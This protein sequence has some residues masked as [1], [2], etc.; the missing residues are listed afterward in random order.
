MRAKSTIP[1]AERQKNNKNKSKENIKRRKEQTAQK[2]AHYVNVVFAGEKDKLTKLAT[3][4]LGEGKSE[5]YV[6]I[7]VRQEVKKIVDFFLMSDE[8][9]DI[10]VTLL[11]RKMDPIIVGLKK[12]VAVKKKAKIEPETKYERTMIRRR[13][14]Y[15]SRRKAPSSD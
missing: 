13:G 11:M 1:K 4:L 6:F 12:S 10:F 2:L 14:F 7:Q 5:R 9:K 15:G 8:A 3:R